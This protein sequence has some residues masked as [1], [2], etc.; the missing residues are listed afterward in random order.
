MQVC[1]KYQLITAIHHV[2]ELMGATRQ[3][4]WSQASWSQAG[5][6]IL[7]IKQSPLNALNAIGSYSNS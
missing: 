4:S 7:A 6:I 2:M 3:S 1:L 5:I